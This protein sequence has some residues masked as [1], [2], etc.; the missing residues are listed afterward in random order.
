MAVATTKEKKPDSQ[1]VEGGTELAAL[2]PLTGE[3]VKGKTP[4]HPVLVTKIDNTRS[5]SP[6]VGLEK[7]DLV[8]E[9][10]VEGGM[11]RLA[12]FFYRHLPKVAGPVR[13]MRA[14]DIGIVKPAHGVI[15]ASGGAGPTIAPDEAGQG[16]LRHRGWPGLLPRGR[17]VGAVQPDGAACPSSRRP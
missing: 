8:T 11:T 1:P 5:S 16:S 7:A 10:L 6:Q 13:S 14:S 17:P 4:N 12:V 9:E 3:P 15:V 2:W